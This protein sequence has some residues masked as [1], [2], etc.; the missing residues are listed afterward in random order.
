MELSLAWAFFCKCGFLA[1]GQNL[2]LPESGENF[3][4]GPQDGVFALLRP[5]KYRIASFV[6]KKTT[7]ETHW[8]K[9]QN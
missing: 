8:Q 9:T 1:L 5:K 6:S 4:S 3:A 7:V 2:Y